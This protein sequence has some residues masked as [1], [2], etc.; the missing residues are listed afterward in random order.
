MGVCVNS[1]YAKE[2]REAIDL[3]PGTN[4]ARAASVKIAPAKIL[5]FLP[6]LAAVLSGLLLTLCFPRWDQGWVCWIALTPLISAI[7][8]GNG[9]AD[10]RSHL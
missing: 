3:E 10:L 7:L 8:F 1:G 9:S 4:K 2:L 6:W 5:R